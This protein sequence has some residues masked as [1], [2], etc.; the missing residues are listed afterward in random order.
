MGTTKFLREKGLLDKDKEKFK[1]IHDEVGEISLNDLLSEYSKK[2]ESY[3]RLAAEFDNYKKRTQKEKKELVDNTKSKTISSVLDID[4]DISIAI[5]SI[6]NKE[7]KE[8]LQLILKKLENFLKSQGIESIQTENY[9]PDVHEVIS[10][11]ESDE[12]KI[13]DV[14]S[15]GYKINDKVF[16]HPKIVLG[17]NNE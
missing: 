3:I 1:I 15:K 14:I 10:V 12:E 11:I 6:K 2:S 13:I 8:G 5:R 9:D 7:A 4:N 16:R 17:K